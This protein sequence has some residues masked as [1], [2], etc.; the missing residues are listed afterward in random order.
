MWTNLLNCSAFDGQYFADLFAVDY[1]QVYEIMRSTS[2][3]PDQKKKKFKNPIQFQQCLPAT[4]A[5]PGNP[6]LSTPAPPL[7]AQPPYLLYPSTAKPSAAQPH[8]AFHEHFAA[9][10]RLFPALSR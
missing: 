4:F 10:P 2:I 3:W 7:T 6:T 9:L 8:Q 1:A 5:S